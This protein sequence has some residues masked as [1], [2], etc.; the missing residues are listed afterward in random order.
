MRQYTLSSIRKTELELQLFNR[1]THSR[2]FVTYAAIC[3]ATFIK[4]VVAKNTVTVR[5]FLTKTNYF[6]NIFFMA[7]IAIANFLGLM[8]FVVKFHAMFEYKD[9]SS[10]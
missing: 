5:P 8:P 2:R 6:A 3:A 7:N 10:K 1:I 4:Q 9:I